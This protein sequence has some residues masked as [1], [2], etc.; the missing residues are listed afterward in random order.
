MEG[1]LTL[2]GFNPKSIILTQT[3]TRYAQPKWIT[4]QSNKI[5]HPET[6]GHQHS[7]EIADN[8]E[9]GSPAAIAENTDWISQTIKNTDH[10]Q[11]ELKTPTAHQMFHAPK[12]PAAHKLITNGIVRQ[13]FH[14]N[15][16]LK[17][18]TKI[19]Q[20]SNLQ[21]RM[22]MLNWNDHWCRL[23]QEPTWLVFEPKKQVSLDQNWSSV[24]RKIKEISF[25]LKALIPCQ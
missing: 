2:R 23:H 18:Q 15:S 10:R 22:K 12:S 4:E 21:P 7:R 1:N 19:N 20:M 8:Q 17:R 16:D 6:R 14:Q 25:N 3:T 5:N 11:Q 13:Q 24:T 9:N